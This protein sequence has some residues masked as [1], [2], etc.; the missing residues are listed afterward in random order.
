MLEFGCQTASAH[1][2]WRRTTAKVSNAR[3]DK[4]YGLKNKF[5]DRPV[6]SKQG[7]SIDVRPMIQQILNI[8]SKNSQFNHF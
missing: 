2:F 1:D 7:D 3:R 4:M 6:S 5:N 8:E